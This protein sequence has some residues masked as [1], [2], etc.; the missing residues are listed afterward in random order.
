MRERM[1]SMWAIGLR[2]GVSCRR[3]IDAS[4]LRLALGVS[5][6]CNH[7]M[8]EVFRPV[9]SVKEEVSFECRK[10]RDCPRI[11]RVQRL[12]RMNL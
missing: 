10:F 4:V 8:T 11:L 5:G 3:S 9:K 1:R 7:G 2:N 6:V 12:D